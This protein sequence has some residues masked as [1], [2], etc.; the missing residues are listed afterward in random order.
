MVE[1]RSK[2]QKNAFNNSPLEN[3]AASSSPRAG[4]RTT[5]ERRSKLTTSPVPALDRAGEPEKDDVVASSSRFLEHFSSSSLLCL[6]N[7]ICLLLF[8]ASFVVYAMTSYNTVPGG[9]A[10]ELIISA[11][12]LGTAHPPGYPTWTLLGHLFSKVQ[13]VLPEKSV[14][15]CVGISSGFC[16]A[17]SGIFMVKTISLLTGGNWQAGMLATGMFLFSPLVWGCS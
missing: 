12:Q 14:A 4:S 3:T 5:R 17:L 8:F 1:T 2:T 15:W 7:L 16:S 10:P 13:M 6:E 9:D 11:Y